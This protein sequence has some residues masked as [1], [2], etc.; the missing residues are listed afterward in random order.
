MAPLGQN[1]GH[2]GC[3][4]GAI[5]HNAADYLPCEHNPL[6]TGSRTYG[7]ETVQGAAANPY[8]DFR[9][10][11]AADVVRVG[12]RLY[13]VYEGIR[14]PGPGDAGDTQFGLGLARTAERAVMAPTARHTV[15]G[16]WETYPDNPL[17]VNLPGNVG[18]GHADLVILENV[19]YLYT[20]LNG[21]T[22]CR[23]KLVWHP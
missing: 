14:G 9:T 16:P 23:L 1:P 2:I 3:Y 22:R 20:S 15:D 10:L 17:L 18:L 13:M 5:T 11:S 6:I 12:R 7:P 4:T 8:F 21:E 19:T